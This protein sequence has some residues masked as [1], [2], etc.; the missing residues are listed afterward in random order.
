[1]TPNLKREDL[2]DDHRSKG[3]ATALTG[4]VG[5]LA[6]ICLVWAWSTTA[7]DLFGAP[8]AGFTDALATVLTL[9]LLVYGMGLAFRLGRSPS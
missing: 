8:E 1:M 4:I 5:L 2:G 9:F 6:S 7:V 3:H